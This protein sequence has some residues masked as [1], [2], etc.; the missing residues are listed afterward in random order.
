MSHMPTTEQ[1]AAGSAG[2]GGIAV[3]YTATGSEGTS[4]NVSIGQT[5][6]DADYYVSYAPQGVTNIPFVDLPQTGRTT[7]TF[8]VVLAAPLAAGEKIL[9]LIHT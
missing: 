2:S 6:A 1:P 9:F 4:F 7:T 8:P 3:L 5:L